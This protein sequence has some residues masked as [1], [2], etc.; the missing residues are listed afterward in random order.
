MAH[1]A[2]LEAWRAPAQPGAQPWQVGGLARRQQARPRPP[3]NRRLSRVQLGAGDCFRGSF[4]AARY[5]ERRGVEE[6][7]RWAAAAASL[8]VEVEGA[9]PSM[10]SRAAIAARAQSEMRSDLFA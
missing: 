2:F 10:P 1:P 4:V 3:S 8:A 7:M 5:G 6:A 9:M